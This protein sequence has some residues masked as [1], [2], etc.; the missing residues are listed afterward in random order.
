MRR[1]LPPIALLVL[2][3][4]A[5][6][7]PTPLPNEVP[8]A[9]LIA[10]PTSG[11]VPFDVELDASGS[12]DSDGS[13]T[14]KQLRLD[15]GAFV[16]MTTDPALVTVTTAGDHTYT[17]RVTD[18]DG[19]S[20]DVTLTLT[21]FAPAPEVDE[22]LPGSLDLD[23]RLE[24][25]TVSGLGI[26]NAAAATSAL[27][28]TIGALPAWLSVSPTSA[29][30][31]VGASQDFV[32][33]AACGAIEETR[34]ATVEIATNDPD[35]PSKS[36][37]VT[38]SCTAEPPPGD[39]RVEIVPS[40]ADMTAA[41]LAVFEGAAARWAE[42]ITGDLPG[43]YLAQSDTTTYCGDYTYEG[44]VDDVVIFAEIAP[45]DGE[46][47]ILGQAGPC[48][49]T[50]ADAS[51]PWMPVAGI[52]TFDSADIASMEA[53]GTFQGVILHEMGHVLH[54]NSYAFEDVFGLLSYDGADCLSSSVVEFTGASARV[55][56]AALGSSGN[57]P[58]EDNGIQGTGCGHWDEETFG[59][60]LM[61]GYAS[62]DMP[63]SRQTIGALDDLG[64][65]VDYDVADAYSLPL[66]SAARRDTVRLQEVIL[67]PRG[68][69]NPDGTVT[70][71]PAA[72]DRV[73]DLHLPLPDEHD[74]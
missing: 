65:D 58:I 35:E 57:V 68:V 53:D 70:P 73:L 13:I 15:S 7:G 44:A 60:E 64:F 1:I 39:F 9:R 23:A 69:L 49:F 22:P 28:L 11:T 71:L 21:G 3:A 12:R 10:T 72:S 66:T 46:G 17:L 52:M 59:D 47:G 63:L 6:P 26:G 27:E 61:T 33:T 56:W 42:V 32:V 14:R 8:T 19:A 38:L 54:L 25:S 20:D 50:R 36:A 18:D 67:A 16:D 4:C 24:Q 55:E 43:G 51:S 30:V 48:L 34:S 31:P 74:H 41:R 29:T 5:E 2:A 37:A 45:I 62:L 40:G